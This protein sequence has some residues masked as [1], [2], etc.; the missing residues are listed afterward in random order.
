[1]SAPAATRVLD[2]SD[3]PGTVFG[4]RSTL[5][6]GTCG[7]MVV[8]GATLAVAA[9]SFVY[10]RKNF[11]TWPPAP[12]PPPDLI[13]PTIGLVLLLAQIPLMRQARNHAHELDAGR[14][15]AWLLWTAAAG[16]GVAVCRALEFEAVNVRWDD[17][18][19][20]SGVWLMLGLHATLVI[21][22]IVETLGL[23]AILKS[24]RRKPKH[25]SDVDDAA[26]YQYFLSLS[27]VPLYVLVYLA[28][29]VFAP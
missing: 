28:P 4:H 1:M 16:I 15:V 13:A 6:W 5:W 11:P 17:H 14:T 20:G 22:D 7:F 27:W 21:T 12:Y 9:W 8:E 24:R 10:L 18:A 29:R 23:A 3:L 19:Y 26:L 2:V 25:F